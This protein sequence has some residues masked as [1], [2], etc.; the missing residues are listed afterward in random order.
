M[1]TNFVITPEA[2]KNSTWSNL[3]LVLTAQSIIMWN[4]N[5]T[6]VCYP[7]RQLG[8]TK[9]YIFNLPENA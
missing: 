2:K 8:P 3:L 5:W 9:N 4:R 7:F 1:L 6:K